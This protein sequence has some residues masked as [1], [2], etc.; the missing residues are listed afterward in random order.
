MSDELTDIDPHPIYPEGPVKAVTPYPA[1]VAGKTTAT[2]QKDF[3][4]TSSYNKWFKHVTRLAGL[5][6]YSIISFDELKDDKKQSTKYLSNEKKPQ[7]NVVSEDIKLP[8]KIGDTILTGRFK[9]KKTIIKTIGKDEHGMPTINGRKVVN[10]R[11]VKEGTCL[12]YTS[13]SPRD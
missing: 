12:L 7:G 13:P 5:V 1:G 9:N 6:G 4:G 10:F 8:V 3:Y 2:N 11:I